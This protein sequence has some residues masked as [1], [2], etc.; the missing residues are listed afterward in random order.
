M[1]AW[2]TFPL[3]GKLRA[4]TIAFALSMGFS[5]VYLRHHYILDVIVGA[6]LALPVAILAQR[7][8]AYARRRFEV[9]A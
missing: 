8:A 7:L 1:V 5:A 4:A 9:F 2:V 3:G 6:L